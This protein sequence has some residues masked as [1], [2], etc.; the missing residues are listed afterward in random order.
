MTGVPVARTT[1]YPMR[2]LGIAA[3][4]VL[5]LV[6]LTVT[7]GVLGGLPFPVL[8]LSFVAPSVA[9]MLNLVWFGV[10]MGLVIWGVA[11]SM[12]GLVTAPVVFATLWAGASVANRWRLQESIDPKVWNSS[13]SPEAGGQ[14]T[15]IMDAWQ[16]VDRKII[17]D[18]H[19]DRLVKLEHD[20]SSHKLAGIEEISLGKGDACSAD[21]KRASPQLQNAGRPDECFKR[22]K[23]AEIP[24]GLVIE[25]SFRIAVANGG[26]G[27]CNET[28][29]RLRR[30]GKERLLSSWFQ[31]QAYVL[32]YLPVLG[33][34]SQ[35]T[36][37][38]EGGSGLRHPV[39]YGLDDISPRRMTSAIYGAPPYNQDQ[40]GPTLSFGDSEDVLDRAATFAKQ[41]NVSQKSVAS[42]LINARDKGLVDERALDAAASLIGHDNE[43]WSAISNYAKGLTNAQTETLLGKVLQ[44]LETPDICDDCVPSERFS[45]PSLRDWKLRERLSNFDA[46]ND[47]A[48]QTFVERHDLAAWQYEGLLRIITGLGPQAYPANVNFLEGSILPMVLVDDTPA[49][50]EKAIA[51]LRGSSRR[52]M[53]AAAKLGAKFD[54]VR[55]RDLK[56]YMATIWGYELDK[57]PQ[58]NA[59]PE[60]YVI[61][62]AACERIARI[63]DPALRAQKF[64]VDCPVPS[65]PLSR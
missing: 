40:G 38:W 43:G 37:L 3:Q 59:L 36:T 14:R 11:R 35:S 10:I 25:E 13:I 60:T 12:P 58:R 22:R 20:N 65:R 64:G 33:F 5:G 54:L 16:S 31:G 57:L 61:A 1:Q 48:I 51:Y 45:Y 4:I 50:S 29:A 8:L 17:A 32:S 47:R 24:D 27:C 9:G 6:I 28:Q 15:L 56:E 44:R 34:F 7:L 19:V 18:G 52:P 63:S 21:E 53:G 2:I 26:A 42:L 49:F 30:D 41:V 55:D 23:L 46:F 62:S 39:R